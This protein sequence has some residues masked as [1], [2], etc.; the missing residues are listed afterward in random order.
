M[1]SGFSPTGASDGA[2]QADLAWHGGVAEVILWEGT[3][4]LWT[5][6]FAAIPLRSDIHDFPAAY[7]PS[8]P[9]ANI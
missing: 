3:P 4:R 7:R 6:R 8:N 2:E 5:E 1:A 9:I